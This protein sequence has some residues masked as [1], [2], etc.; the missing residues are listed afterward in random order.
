[1]DKT[2]AWTEHRTK[3]PPGK[4]TLKCINAKRGGI[5]HEGKRGWSR[6]E[7]VIVWF[8]VF[9]GD[10]TGAIIPMYLTLGKHGKIP[11]GSKYFHAWCIANGL[12]RP[13]KNRLK[14][15]PPSKFLNKVFGGEVVNVK[16]KYITGEQQPELFHYSRVDILY[17]LVIGNPDT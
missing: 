14:E 7:K 15:M 3:I 2:D 4:Y 5:W 6:S 1:M 16:P 11:Q 10:H 9:D 8:E 12:R 13:L 17:E